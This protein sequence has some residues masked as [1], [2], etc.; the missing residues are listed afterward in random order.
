MTHLELILELAKIQPNLQVLSTPDKLNTKSRIFV[1]DELSILYNSSISM[2]LNGYIP[3]MQSA[4]NKSEWLYKTLVNKDTNYRN[5]IFI[6]KVVTKETPLYIL[7]PIGIVHKITPKSLLKNVNITILS[8]IDKTKYFITNY[9]HLH[10]TST[11]ENFKYIHKDFKT[12]ATCKLHGDYITTPNKLQQS[13]GCSTCGYLNTSRSL[14]L[15]HRSSKAIHR[16]WSHS[17][18]INAANISKNFDSFKVYI[19]RLYN[20]TEN[21]IK[22]GKTFVTI[23]SRFERKR[24]PYEYELISY[25]EGDG[26][27]MS[28]L[29]TT[30]HSKLK[31]YK[32]VPSLNF[33]GSTECFTIE[34]LKDPILL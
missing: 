20:N 25:A 19:I 3:S 2:L 4:W 9:K 13:H 16:G 6:S 11:F 21:F 28:I 5:Y 7:S 14:Q 27:T 23:K 18:W 29:E 8:A 32:Y 24:P 26:L 17:E 31:E 34:S 15:Y 12:V 22:I 10:P 33:D 30:L 1:L